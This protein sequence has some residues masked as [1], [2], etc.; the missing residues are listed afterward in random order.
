MSDVLRYGRKTPGTARMRRAFDQIMDAKN[1]STTASSYDCNWDDYDALVVCAMFY[2][3]VMAS[4]VVPAG[5]FSETSSTFR[6]LIT[7]PENSRRYGV[8]KNGDGAVY[9]KTESG[10]AGANYGVRIY[11]VNLG[12]G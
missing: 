12:G 9:A 11:G 8:W 7:D 4:V 3:N 6:V 1:I 5:Y 2:S 10:A